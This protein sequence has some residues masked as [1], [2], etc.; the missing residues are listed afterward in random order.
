MRSVLYNNSTIFYRV[1][2]LGNP[3]IFLHGFLEN[4]SIWNTIATEIETLGFKVVLIDLPCH[5]KSRFDGSICSMQFMAKAVQKIMAEEKISNPFIFGHSLGGYVALEIAKLTPI[6]LT[7]VHSNF[8]ADSEN[9]KIDRNRVV[10]IVEKN[11]SRLLNEAIPNLFAEVNRKKCLPTINQLISD[12]EIIPA[13]EIIACTRGMRDRLDN[14]AIVEKTAIN[15]I[16]GDL[17]TVV[18]PE[19]MQQQ[20]KKISHNVNLITIKN[21]GHM[22]IWESRNQLISCI[23]T[24]VI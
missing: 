13:N 14:K 22:S 16:Q 21:C 2:G 19:I 15:C 18:K 23:K 20:L 3:V 4:H 11:K 10:S 6:K 24:I 7:L 12:A 9:K 17:D 8:W 1:S 5:G